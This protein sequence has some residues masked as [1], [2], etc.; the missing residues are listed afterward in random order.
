VHEVLILGAGL[1]TRPI[2]RFFLDCEDVRLT[3]AT[4]YHED[5]LGL[6]ENH[7][8]GIARAVDVTEPTELAPLLNGC[9]LV[10]SLVPFAFHAQVARIA[11][12]HRVP[13][14]TTS[15]VSPEMRALDQQARD[16]GIM[17]LNEVG[18]DPGL[19]H[20]AAVRMIDEVHRENGKVVELS[21][22]CGGLPAPEAADNPWRYKFS[23]SPRGALLAGRLSARHLE[24]GQLKYVP[25]TELFGHRWPIEIEGVGEF[26]VYPNRDSLKYVEL[27]GLHDVT[28]MF[29]GT[30][31]YPGW[32]ETMKIVADLDLLDVEERDWA[33][34]TT[35][36][37]FISAALPEETGDPESRMSRR[38][39][40]DTNSPIV[41]RFRWAG[42]LDDEPIGT[43]R[44]S[45]LDVLAER[46]QQRMAY[47]DGERDMV[48]QRHRLTASW[49]ADRTERWTS[50]LVAYGASGG[51]SATSRTVSLPA[52]LAARLVLDGKLNHPGVQIPNRLELAGP[53]LDELE[54]RGIAFV[55]RREPIRG[56]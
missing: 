2:V 16:S 23:W 43:T 17:L 27:Y 31:R 47:V 54:H 34:G 25:G 13:M 53:I 7:P 8:R 46:F 44:A 18:L 29:R 28:S 38:F 52:A 36:A 56:R 1:V 4:L 3:V 6:V 26:E 50:V 5:A 20:M 9:E 42:L 15:Y 39:G 55:E 49:S 19:D 22:S 41:D 33:P 45:P 14:V 51:D 32:C 24:D 11:L 30:I 35:Y 21:S 12:D 37:D 10:V 48:L 40:L